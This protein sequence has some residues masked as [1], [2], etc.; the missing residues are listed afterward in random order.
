MLSQKLSF[1]NKGICIAFF[2]HLHSLILNYRSMFRGEQCR[3][4]TQADLQGLSP[5]GCECQ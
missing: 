5:N 3:D 4:K 1:V 2:V